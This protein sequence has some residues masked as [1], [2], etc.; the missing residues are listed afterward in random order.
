[1]RLAAE[2]RRNHGD[3]VARQTSL[4]GVAFLLDDLGQRHIH[5]HRPSIACAIARGEEPG[6]NVRP[7]QK[8]VACK[9]L[10]G[11]KL[12]QLSHHAISH[13][14]ELGTFGRSQRAAKRIA[15]CLVGSDR[16]GHPRN[17]LR[18]RRV[19]QNQTYAVFFQ[20]HLAG[21]FVVRLHAP[22]QQHLAHTA[23]KAFTVACILS[24]RIV[25][26]Q[27]RIERRCILQPAYP[28]TALYA[29]KCRSFSADWYRWMR[30]YCIVLRQDK[31]ACL[32]FAAIRAG[33]TSRLHQLR[34]AILGAGGRAD[35]LDAGDAGFRQCLE[36]VCLANAVL[37]QVAP[38]THISVLRI[39][40]VE[41]LVAGTAGGTFGTTH[42]QFGQGGK[43]VS[44]FLPVGQQGFVAKKFPARVNHAIAVAV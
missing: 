2:R 30:G 33:E 6:L 4:R 25:A 39:L 14:V 11:V 41:Q 43:T 17:L 32:A 19:S 27:A 13:G 28:T 16:H 22:L 10:I 31:A 37:I 44:S 7:P 26:E 29:G 42:V 18:V 1:M 15:R 8:G 20:R 3:P 40:R 36:F 38:D 21:G 12:F 34:I 23:D 9:R 35:Q 5:S 24:L